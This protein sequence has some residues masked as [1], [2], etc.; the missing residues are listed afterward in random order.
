M[1]VYRLHRGNADKSIHMDSVRYGMQVCVN[2]VGTADM[3]YS[4]AVLSCKSYIDVVFETR[5]RSSFHHRCHCCAADAVA[6]HLPNSTHSGWPARP[7]LR[8]WLPSATLP[9]GTVR[10]HGVAPFSLVV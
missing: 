4:C 10:G 9:L 3:R 8:G 7:F 2:V 5:S 1:C 6:G